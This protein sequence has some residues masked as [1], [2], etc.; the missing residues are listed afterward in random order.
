MLVGKG[1][2]GEGGLMELPQS[3]ASL[4]NERKEKE[5]GES[6]IEGKLI[7]PVCFFMLPSS[8]GAMRK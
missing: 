8:G 6:A 4:G 3:P 2:E 1:G 5:E 7:S